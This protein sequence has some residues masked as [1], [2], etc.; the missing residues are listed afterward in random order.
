[1]SRDNIWQN[2]QSPGRDSNQVQGVMRSRVKTETNVDPNAV[3]VINDIELL[4]PP[5]QIVVK[6]ENLHWSWKTLRSKVSTKVPSGNAINY[7]GLTIVFTPDMLL[8]LHRLVVQ[9]KQSPFCYVENSFLRQSLCGDWSN[10]QKMAFTMTNLNV[11]NMPGFPGSFIVQLEMRWFNYRCFSPNFLFKDEWQTQPMRISS[12]KKADAEKKYIVSTIDTVIGA[13]YEKGPTYLQY[14]EKGDLDSYSMVLDSLADSEHKLTLQDLLNTHSGTVF[15]LLPLPDRMQRSNPVPP[16]LSNIYVRYI[17]DLQM[18]SLYRSFGIDVY[19]T[20]EENVAGQSF[21]HLT[22][23]QAS[24]NTERHKGSNLATIVYG[25]HTFN[26]P[27]GVT[28]SLTNQ[29]LRSM[30]TLRIYYDQY[31]V[32]DEPTEIREIKFAIKK[33]AI[34][35]SLDLRKIQLKPSEYKSKSIEYVGNFPIIEAENIDVA[36][37][38]Y[39]NYKKKWDSWKK[40]KAT[41][42]YEMNNENPSNG[43]LI[44]NEKDLLLYPPVEYGKVTSAFGMRDRRRINEEAGTPNKPPFSLHEGIDLVSNVNAEMKANYFGNKETRY[45]PSRTDSN[46]RPLRVGGVTPIF[47]IEEGILTIGRS[48]GAG[49]SIKIT[50]TTTSPV[51]NE[52]GG[53]TTMTSH[54]KHLAEA[55]DIDKDYLNQVIQA[56]SDK[57]CHIT[58]NSGTPV[59]PANGVAVKRGDIIGMMGNT[60]GSTGPHLHFEVR[61]DG[62]PQD[63]WLFLNAKHDDIGRLEST[64]EENDDQPNYGTL[65][66]APSMGQSAE[67]ARMTDGIDADFIAS[68]SKTLENLSPDGVI[69]SVTELERIIN[70][71]KK[72]NYKSAWI[73]YIQDMVALKVD[74]YN[75]Y[76]GD[77]RASNVYYRTRVLTYDD[78]EA[79]VINGIL[80][81]SVASQN[82]TEA[83]K[84][85]ASLDQA[86]ALAE[87]I[88]RKKGLIVTALGGSLQHIVA[89]I[90]LVGMEYPTHQHLGSVEPNYYFEMNALSDSATSLRAD[91]LDAEAQAYLAVQNLLQSNAKSFRLVPDSHSLCIDSFI[92][93][94]LGSFE[95]FDVDV[96]Q[97]QDEYIGMVRLTKRCLF[98]N[99]SISTIEG[100]PGRCSIFSQ[101]AETNPYNDIEKIN[102]VIKEDPGQLTDEVIKEALKKVDNLNLT[103]HGKI[104]LMLATFG[105]VR[106]SNEAEE[107]FEEKKLTPYTAPEGFIVTFETTEEFVSNNSTNSTTEEILR[108]ALV[109]LEKE[110]PKGFYEWTEFLGD[111]G[112]DFFERNLQS[113][114]IDSFTGGVGPILNFFLDEEDETV[115]SHEKTKRLRLLLQ[116]HGLSVV[117]KEIL[118]SNHIVSQEF[119]NTFLPSEVETYILPDGRVGIEPTSMPLINRHYSGY[120]TDNEITAGVYQKHDQRYS[121][122]VEKNVYTD[123]DI[124]VKDIDDFLNAYPVYQSLTLNKGRLPQSTSK[125]AG[126]ETVLFYNKAIAQ[127]KSLAY[128]YLAEEYLGGLD[129]NIIKKD[130]YEILIE[131]DGKLPTGMMTSFLYWSYLWGKEWI[132]TA[133]AKGDMLTTVLGSRSSLNDSLGYTVENIDTMFDNLRLRV[134]NGSQDYESYF[135]SQHPSLLEVANKAIPIETKYLMERNITL[136]S[137]RD[138]P[139]FERTFTSGFDEQVARAFINSFFTAPGNL[140]SPIDKAPVASYLRDSALAVWGRSEGQLIE[141]FNGFIKRRSE[142]GLSHLRLNLGGPQYGLTEDIINTY[143]PWLGGMLNAFAK[144]KSGLFAAGF[145]G[146]STNY[147]TVSKYLYAPR[148]ITKTSAESLYSD[149]FTEEDMQG[150]DTLDKLYMQYI[151]LKD[152]SVQTAL[153]T[154]TETIPNQLSANLSIMNL[155]HRGAFTIATPIIVPLDVIGNIDDV[156]FQN[157]NAIYTDADIIQAGK[158]LH[159]RDSENLVLGTAQKLFGDETGVQDQNRNNEFMRFLANAASKSIEELTFARDDLRIQKGNPFVLNLKSLINLEL[160]RQKLGFIKENLK[161]LAKQI[162]SNEEV[163]FAIG[164]DSIGDKDVLRNQY[165]GIECYNDLDLPNHPYYSNKG[166]YATS[167]DFYM[168]DVGQDGPGGISKEVRSIVNKNIEASV[169]NSYH[170]MKRMQKGIVPKHDRGLSINTPL[171]QSDQLSEAIRSNFEGSDTNTIHTAEGLIEVGGAHSA[172]HQSIENLSEGTLDYLAK[173]GPAGIKTLKAKIEEQ[174]QLAEAITDDI[175]KQK[176]LTA[177]K[178]AEDRIQYIRSLRDGTNDYRFIN[179]LSNWDGTVSQDTSGL[180]LQSYADLIEQSVSIE[181]MFGSKAGY[182]GIYLRKDLKATSD[183]FEDVLDT[184]VAANDQ[185]LHQFDPDT[186]KQLAKDSTADIVSNKFSMKRAYP[187]FKLFFIEEDE[188]ESRF[189]NFDDFYSYNGVKEFTV[190]QSRTNPGDVATIVLQNVAG[191]LDGT[192]RTGIS[193]I[194]YFEKKKRG[195]IAYEKGTN[196]ELDNFQSGSDIGTSVQEQPFDSIVLRPGTNVQLR[197]GYSND[198]DML[199]VMISGRVTEIN[200]GG[201]GDI[202]EMTVQSFGTELSQYVKSD[203]RSFYTTHQLLGAMMLEPE[204]RHFGRFEFGNRAQYGED[205]NHTID[206]YDYSLNTDKGRWPVT[207]AIGN[208]FRDHYFGIAIGTATTIALAAIFRKPQLLKTV[209]DLPWDKLLQQTVKAKSKNFLGS[210]AIGAEDVMKWVFKTAFLSPKLRNILGTP[211]RLAKVTAPYKGIRPVNRVSNAADDLI[212]SLFAHRGNYVQAFKNYTQLLKSTSGQSLKGFFSGVGGKKY[213]ELH[214][215]IVKHMREGSPVPMNLIKDYGNMVR[216]MENFSRVNSFYSGAYGTLKSAGILSGPG[217]LALGRIGISSI[218]SSLG[219]IFTVSAS[220][221][222][223]SIGADKMYTHAIQQ[224]I[225]GIEAAKRFHAKQKSKILL[226]PADDNLYPPNPTS[227]LRFENYDKGWFDLGNILFKLADVTSM[228]SLIGTPIFGPEFDFN[229]PGQLKQAYLAMEN[230]EYHVISKRLTVE[231]S[232]YK[233]KGKRIWDIFQEMMLKHPGWIT[234]VR[235]YGNKFQYTMFFGVPTQRYWSKPATPFFIKRINKLRQYLLAKQVSINVLEH[236]W[237]ELYGQASWDDAFT[238]EVER[239]SVEEMSYVRGTIEDDGL[240]STEVFT[241]VN[242]EDSIMAQLELQFRSQLLREYLLSLENR[243]VPFRRYHML[244]SDEDIVQNN[245]TGSMHNVANAVNVIYYDPDG[246]QP[247]SSVKMKA[248]SR[249]PDNKLNMA[250]LDLGGNVRGYNSAL[251]YGQGALTF[252]VRE[253]YRGELLILGNHRVRPWDICYVFDDYNQMSGPVEVK[254]VTHMFSHETGF[255]TEIVPNAVV[256][257]NEIST[258]PV[259]EALKIMMGAKISLKQGVVSVDTQS[260]VINTIYDE[261]EANESWEAYMQ[262]RYDFG[263]DGK[264]EIDMTQMLPDIVDPEIFRGSGPFNKENIL[265][266][267]GALND[268]VD[269]ASVVLDLY[270]SVDVS[271]IEA[272]LG[273]ITGGAIGYTFNRTGILA[274]LA[275]SFTLERTVFGP[276]NVNKTARFL[277]SKRGKF[278]IIAGLAAIGATATG[279]TFQN[280]SSNPSRKWLLTSPFILNK[281]MENEAVI[282][283]PLLKNNIPIAPGLSMKDPTST[284]KNVIGNIVNDVAESVIGVHDELEE[285]Q[286]YG[287]LFWQRYEQASTE[288]TAFRNDIAKTYYKAQSYLDLIYGE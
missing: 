31:R 145:T 55:R 272:G 152:R 168:W 50:H 234:A 107:F 226:S 265:E 183:I 210:L 209:D 262:E 156:F 140:A 16:F 256:I 175:Q 37:I 250:N 211:G 57:T 14:T 184:A 191:T 246:E 92:T 69:I 116:D 120:N 130:S 197:V 4:I 255:L 274:K 6:K 111:K 174:K 53:D 259:L 33:K 136:A 56:Y 167:P 268:T 277:L 15:D 27:N 279:V 287:D 161:A 252:G 158:D 109:Q 122:G 241:K 242:R 117:K 243:F 88:L 75:L 188:F 286:Q 137:S 21:H 85:S 207:H 91:G 214:L 96:L 77:Y 81:E 232:I 106:D 90:P 229:Y 40:T 108:A 28:N 98:S 266:I 143:L 278:G 233:I 48:S 39:K 25:L 126:V 176:K 72:P 238:Q 131:E 8:S 146:M 206:F 54:Y 82:I 19:Q 275:N 35:R 12:S 224:D 51:K 95:L 223:M 169:M 114:L 124:F 228:A 5:T 271:G 43:K 68:Q 177:I 67:E 189:I 83:I 282:V 202:C 162:L 94:L 45:D 239:Y 125:I 18:K 46:N 100:F 115:V 110:D 247:Y 203:D 221:G 17:N 257:A 190:T 104:A 41:S 260:E 113:N 151:N 74:G 20:Y 129:L 105:Q 99:M 101:F 93:K 285:I 119:L 198:P 254:S 231:Q 150:Q 244:T 173:E 208:F 194:A 89:N 213:K 133:G 219:R 148:S 192:K 102:T 230:P 80:K 34:R 201:N 217:V 215:Q 71:P 38:D 164:M 280:W 44:P 61:I 196:V 193:D 267:A 251:R 84:G 245:I 49:V 10:W 269:S 263:K 64:Q 22:V 79:S 112:Y 261:P 26:I 235:P 60:G 134:M 180:Q 186:L 147:E 171:H 52:S 36:N 76:I 178:K 170:F 258:Y 157:A 179:K 123:T 13:N 160:E 288:G 11:S 1:M 248:S 240:S 166:L 165:S 128:S 59:L 63:P 42:S 281:I 155:L 218:L 181:K 132:G 276:A 65:E 182:S 118:A 23:G 139:I 185:F 24:S 78:P 205:K 249:I 121:S 127:V 135:R 97:E 154:I 159:K 225:L 58:F 66:Q 187:T 195:E 153:V 222:L 2:F 270:G 220:L 200:W 144:D 3:F 103:E 9:F 7:V 62:V 264:F 149:S 236:S 284:W 216:A 163:A 142:I 86:N 138:L 253:V 204:L 283:V 141:K 29:L 227:Y 172:F 70:N 273:G 87:S 30:E 199:E 237:K 212:Q 73:K 47:A 32:Y